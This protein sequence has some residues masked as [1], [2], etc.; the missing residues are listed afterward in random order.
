MLVPE[1]PQSLSISVIRGDIDTVVLSISTVGAVFEQKP[2]ELE[3]TLPEVCSQ[4]YNY[5]S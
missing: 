1:K 2:P 5:K 3:V 4:I